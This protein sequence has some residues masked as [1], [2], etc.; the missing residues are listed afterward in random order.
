LQDVLNRRWPDAVLK[1]LEQKEPAWMMTAQDA[2]EL[3]T[4]RR[5]VDS[6]EDYGHATKKQARKRRACGRGGADADCCLTKEADELSEASSAQ[7][8]TQ[9]HLLGL[10]STC[11]LQCRR[12]D[13]RAERRRLDRFLAPITCFWAMTILGLLVNMGL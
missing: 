11:R 8:V 12:D 1:H 6:A 2:A 9:R 3:G 5:G 4:R 7:L 13:R 10:K